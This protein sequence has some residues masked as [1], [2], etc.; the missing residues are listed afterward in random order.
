MFSL[1]QV[2][3][4][5]DNSFIF[6]NNNIDKTI[7]EYLFFYQSLLKITFKTQKYNLKYNKNNQ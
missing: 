6:C 7:F 3:S 4:A 5:I 1:K 2:N